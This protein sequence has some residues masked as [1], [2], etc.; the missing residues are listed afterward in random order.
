MRRLVSPHRKELTKAALTDEERL[1]VANAETRFNL[2]TVGGMLLAAGG[3]AS[4]GYRGG[5]IFARMGVRNRGIRM[6]IWAFAI[7]STTVPV[8]CLCKPS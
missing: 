8:S 2:M 3:G 1:I 4:L 7:W 6:G 5:D